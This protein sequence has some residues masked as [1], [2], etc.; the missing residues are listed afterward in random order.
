VLDVHKDERVFL[1]EPVFSIPL[2]KPG[3]GRNATKLQPN[4]KSIRLDKFNASIADESWKLEEIRD[5][6]KGKL[7]LFVHK[8][9]IWIWDGESEK[10]KK[11]V[12]IITKTTDTKPKIKYSISNGN[13]NRAQITAILDEYFS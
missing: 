6:V 3:K 5:T 11:K 9:N 4:I 7:M 1:E 13:Q 10:A 12:L 8:Q 2:S